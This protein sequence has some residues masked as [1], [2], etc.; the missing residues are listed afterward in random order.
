MLTHS[1]RGVIDRAI[2]FAGDRD[3][4]PLVS[5]LVQQGVYVTVG[6]HPKSVAEELL[7]VAD[8]RIEYDTCKLWSL[9]SPQFQRRFPAPSVGEI[10][11]DGLTVG[12]SLVRKGTLGTEEVRLYA[13][14]NLYQLFLPRVDYY[15]NQ[16]YEYI[17]HPD[18]T[19]IMKLLDERKLIITWN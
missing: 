12:G 10:T 13:G 7:D 8:E 17:Y 11:R 5:A 3:F 6:Y 18:E 9:T 4:K 15:G 19:V 1:F 14:S 16:R 2:L